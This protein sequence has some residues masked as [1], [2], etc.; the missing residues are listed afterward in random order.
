MPIS[1]LSAPRRIGDLRRK[2]GS[3]RGVLSPLGC[4]WRKTHLS[5]RKSGE[6][7]LES[8]IHP[9]FASPTPSILEMLCMTATATQL[10]GSPLSSPLPLSR[11]LSLLL[12]GGEYQCCSGLADIHSKPTPFNE[13]RQLRTPRREEGDT[14][15]E[16]EN[17]KDEAI[18]DSPY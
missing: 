13:V 7:T 14:S 17:R 3:G 18:A 8:D 4:L 6:E 9:P 10:A 15:C 5:L 2:Q 16:G 12:P 11:G 1:E